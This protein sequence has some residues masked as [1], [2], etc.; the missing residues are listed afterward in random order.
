MSMKEF[1]PAGFVPL[2]DWDHKQRKNNDGHSVEW[3]LL[4]TA[5]DAGKVPGIRFG[6]SGRWYVHRDLANE[7]L[8]EHK[9]QEAAPRQKAPARRVEAVPGDA[10]TAAMLAAFERRIG[11]SLVRIADALDSLASRAN[12][13]VHAGF[14]IND[15][16][17]YDEGSST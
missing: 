9:A 2:A 8:A 17:T 3:K 15:L 6:G 13:E 16:T 14:G 4:R 10:I 7:F 5:A 1:I 12:A 11:E